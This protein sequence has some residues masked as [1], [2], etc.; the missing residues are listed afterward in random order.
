MRLKLLCACVLLV[1]T[2]NISS[3]NISGRITD[4][5]R[6]PVEFA[7]VVLLALP[8]SA[9]LQGTISGADGSFQL[10]A[11]GKTN[12]I[13]RV[14]CIGY[15]TVH[16][17]YSGAGIM[18]DIPLALDTHMLSEVVVKASLPA[19]RLRGDALVTNVQAGILAKAGS[20]VDVL[21]KIPGIIQQDKS[22]FEVFGRG[23]PLI[24]INGRQVR[25]ASEL[26]SLSSEDIKE[27]ELVTNPGARYDSTVKAVIRIK[28]VKRQGDGFGFDLRSSWYQ[29]DQTDL[30]EEVRMNYRHNGLDVF[31]SFRY[32]YNEYYRTGLLSQNVRAEE[33]WSQVNHIR[34][35]KRS[36][37]NMRTEV[38]L[39]YQLSD[40]HSI[41]AR[42]TYDRTPTANSHATFLGEIMRNGT[43]S[44]V[45]T[46]EN[47][48]NR[49]TSD[50]HRLNAYYNG[51]I[52]KLDV[53]FNADYYGNKTAFTMTAQ[54]D[55]RNGEDREVHTAGRTENRLVAG[56]LIFTYPA[57]GG[58]LSWGAE[59]TYTHRNDDNVEANNYVPTSYSL[60]KEYNTAA[61]AEYNCKLP[62]GQ[63]SAGVRYEHV[64][65]D[66]TDTSDD[67][68]LKRNYDN[69][70]PNVSLAV[71][72]G[73]VQTR[74]SY[75]AKTQ[76]PSYRQ[77]STTV[78]YANRF[79]AETGNPMLKS[80][81]YH[82]ITL[83]ASWKFLQASVSYQQ[84]LDVPFYWS[85][86]W[87]DNPGGVILYYENL[88]KLPSVRV[89]VS[90]TPTVGWWSPRFTAGITKQWLTMDMPDGTLHLDR[91]M[92]TLGW[93][94]SIT[95]PANFLLNVDYMFR[96][97]GHTNNFYIGRGN[98]LLSASLR[99]SFLNDA[100]SITLGASDILYQS[101]QRNTAYSPYTTMS[102]ANSFDTREVYLTVRY[103]FNSGK[104]KYKGTGA[105]SDALRRL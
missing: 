76:R 84:G 100:L 82:D 73:K 12:V 103:R 8:D 69:W 91:P 20:A 60:I 44:D 33:H 45:L 41:G 97:K 19:T 78:V 59:Y 80:A 74:L 85:R 18:G 81:V 63:L 2:A 70:F 104:S 50:A 5:N 40:N 7:N 49:P 98:H 47:Y 62:F 101:K 89:L 87:E 99:K 46:T 48:S 54:E 25:D 36:N 95:L 31:G 83:G 66:Y 15:S 4:D 92:A 13:V 11:G 28:T 26:E 3:Q 34:E 90:A 86:A 88:D 79:T 6:Q 37:Q 23:A 57:W 52:G 16:R 30:I 65:F 61:F 94:N 77:L 96:G 102:I 71:P 39:N 35:H 93:S 24:Y 68:I 1:A 32:A 64:G 43:L 42:Y 72:I 17:N 53:D 58:N 67:E 21:G 14:S 22:S 55:S 51:Q 10:P 56:K 29:W 105:G 75:T 27:V 9:F 38:G